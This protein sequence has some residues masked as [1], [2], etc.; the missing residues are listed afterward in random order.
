MLSRETIYS[1]WAKDALDVFLLFHI[2]HYFCIITFLPC[3]R[4]IVVKI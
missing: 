2:H 1:V 4:Q 3:K